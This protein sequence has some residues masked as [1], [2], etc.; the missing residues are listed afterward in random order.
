MRMKVEIFFILL[1]KVRAHISKI[2]A[3]KIK[4]NILF[5]T[6]KNNWILIIEVISSPPALNPFSTLNFL[7]SDI[8]S[9]FEDFFENL[10][11]QTLAKILENKNDDSTMKILRKILND[12]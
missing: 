7:K 3:T 8:I 12:S 5:I 11:D 6:K 9:E 10:P 1:L 2:L 4:T